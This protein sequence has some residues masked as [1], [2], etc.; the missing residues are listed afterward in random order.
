MARLARA[1]TTWSDHDDEFLD[2]DALVATKKLQTKKAGPTTQRKPKAPA[3]AQEVEKPTTA[4]RRRKLGPLTDNLLLRAWTPDSAEEDREEKHSFKEDVKPRRTR[5]ELRTRNIKPAVAVP[6]SPVDPDEEYVSA[7]EE[8]TIIEEV[9]M[10]GDS[11]HSCDSEGSEFSGSDEDDDDDVFGV[12]TPPSRAPAKPRFQTKDKKVPARTGEGVTSSKE[13]GRQED[14]DDRPR[15][16]S[17]REPPKDEDAASDMPA[18]KRAEGKV[19]GLADT[20]SKLRL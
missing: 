1:P 14:N 15:Q 7:K 18:R 6:S 13:F 3:K 20:L 2:I 16:V 5:V 4:V 10:F 17:A 11:F 9:S 12:D 19:K 8:V